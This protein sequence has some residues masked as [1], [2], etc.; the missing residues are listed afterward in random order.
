M[1]TKTKAMGNRTVYFCIWTVLN[2]DLLAA[3]FRAY[4][5]IG[6]LMVLLLH[7][8]GK[9]G[10]SV[11]LGGLFISGLSIMLLMT[12]LIRARKR[13]LLDIKDQELLEIAHESMMIYLHRKKM[14]SREKKLLRKRLKEH[15]CGLGHC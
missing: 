6:T 7:L 1:K 12:I 4:M 3:R 9:I 13:I 11:A 2:Q 15:A 10:T 14:T 5:A 8:A